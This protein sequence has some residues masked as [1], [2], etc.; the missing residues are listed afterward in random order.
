MVDFTPICN[1]ACA[2]LCPVSR[3]R[4]D[5]KSY[6]TYQCRSGLSPNHTMILFYLL[7]CSAISHSS[8]YSLRICDATNGP[9]CICPSGR[10]YSGCSSIVIC[11]LSVLQNLLVE[12]MITILVR[13][14]EPLCKKLKNMHT[15]SLGYI[16]TC[17]W[18]REHELKKAIVH[19]CFPDGVKTSTVIREGPPVRQIRPFYV[20][21]GNLLSITMGHATK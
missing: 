15:V 14:E 11:N 17:Q 4:G 21:T 19:G 5:L 13:F 20:I 16:A 1:P 2:E 3:S 18:P 10:T 8:V 9:T 7:R 6:H 12:I